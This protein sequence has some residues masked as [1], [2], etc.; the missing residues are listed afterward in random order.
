[1]P[2]TSEAQR[3]KMFVL[4]SRGKITAAQMEDFKKIVR[5]PKK[6]RFKG[7]KRA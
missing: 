3:R 1:M 4:F 5:K 6:K 2:S 7:R